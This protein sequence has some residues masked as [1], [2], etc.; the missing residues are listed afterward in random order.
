M[1]FHFKFISFHCGKEIDIF[2]SHI[3]PTHRLSLWV[4]TWLQLAFSLSHSSC[5][6]KVRNDQWNDSVLVRHPIIVCLRQTSKITLFIKLFF[7]FLTSNMYD[8][9][10]VKQLP[11]ADEIMILIAFWSQ[12]PPLF[13]QKL[14]TPMQYWQSVSVYHP[15]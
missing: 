7:L 14:R 9:F 13:D 2:L 11:S 3:T 10:L 6:L 1:I 5:F 15:Q 8:I 12:W 4:M